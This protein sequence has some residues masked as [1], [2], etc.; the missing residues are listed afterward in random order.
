MTPA[1]TTPAATVLLDAVLTGLTVL[2][3]LFAGPETRS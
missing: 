3:V 2:T 1:G